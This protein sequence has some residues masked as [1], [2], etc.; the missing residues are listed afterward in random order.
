MKSELVA[1]IV[2]LAGATAFPSQTRRRL[3]EQ[4]PTGGRGGR[5]R[6]GRSQER[7]EGCRLSRRHIGPRETT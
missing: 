6:G 7:G 3:Q 4:F 2:I 5:Y 1:A